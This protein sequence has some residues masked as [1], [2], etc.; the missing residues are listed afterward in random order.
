M[1]PFVLRMRLSSDAWN[2]SKICVRLGASKD[3]LSRELERTSDPLIFS[4]AWGSHWSWPRHPL[5]SHSGSGWHLYQTSARWRCKRCHV[6]S[7]EHSGHVP[8]KG[9]CLSDKI[10]LSNSLPQEGERSP[11]TRQIIFPSGEF[12][13]RWKINSLS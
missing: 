13:L 4:L 8:S 9:L 12:L 3:H 1:R 5:L 2:G 11:I 6:L 10:H 7:N